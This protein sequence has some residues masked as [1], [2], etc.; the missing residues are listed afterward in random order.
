VTSPERRTRRTESDCA[1]KCRF[2]AVCLFRQ[3]TFQDPARRRK[4]GDDDAHTTL[5]RPFDH[6]RFC[7]LVSAESLGDHGCSRFVPP[8][9]RQMDR[10]YIHIRTR[11]RDSSAH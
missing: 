1:T 2:V 3:L 8:A 6:V 10:L 5:G 9:D 7:L 11:T 4:V